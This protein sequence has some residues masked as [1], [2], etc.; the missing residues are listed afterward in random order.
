MEFQILGPLEVT[1]D[2][3]P[4]SLP[5]SKQRALLAILVLNANDVVSSDRLI[6]ELYEGHPVDKAL[7]AL[8]VQI[9]ALRKVLE[10]ERSQ[11][12]EDA[13]VV[14]RPPGY[15][16]RIEPG[17]LDLDA[18]DALVSS[19][20]E[21]LAG[22]DAETAS[23]RFRDALA[24]WRGSPLADLALESW[25]QTDI[26]RLEER[27]LGA[28]EERIEADLAL[29]RHHELVAEL[30]ALVADHPLRERIRRQL[31]LALYRCG[32]HAE[33]LAAY[34]DARTTLVDELGIEPSRELKALE[35]AILIQDPA[36][37]L[38]RPADKEPAA[39]QPITMPSAGSSSFVGRERELNEFLAA[40]EDAFGGRTS[41]LLIA[42]E[43]GIGK[44][45]LADELAARAESRGARVLWG[46]C[47]EAGGAPAYWPWVQAL[48]SYIRDAEPDELRKE[49]GAG[50]PEIAEVLPELRE[51]YPD[52]PA[53]PSLDA[54][55]ARFRL[56]DSTA[57][58][59]RAASAA[60]PLVILL[61]DIHAADAPSLLLLRFL[62]RELR[63]GRIALVGAY[64][65]S[66][67]GHDG[68]ITSSVAEL[69]REPITR[70]VGLGG[71][72]LGEMKRFIESTVGTAPGD[73]LAAAIHAETEGNPLFAG[74]LVRLLV[75][76]GRLEEAIRTPWRASIPRG[77]REVIGNRLLQLSDECK[78]LLSVASVL[79]REF[80]L[81]ALAALGDLRE[82]QMAGALDEALA[83]RVV[84]EEPG[85]R[86][87]LRFSHALIRDSLY[88]DLP[89]FERLQLHRRAA[90]VLEELYGAGD[91]QHLAELAHHFTEAAP[92]GGADKAVAYARRAGDRAAALLAYEEAARLYEMA[93][94]ALER[95]AAHDAQRCELLLA[96]GGAQS[97]GGDLGAA[98]ETFARAADAARE[99]GAP[100]QLG[101]AAL[102]YG[103][104][105]VWFR[106]GKDLRLLELLDEALDG[107]PGDSPL[108]A[109]LLARLAGALRD[110][111]VPERRA[112]LT[113]ESVEIARRLGDRATLAYALEGTYA[114]LSLP[115]DPDAWL[116]MG[117]ELCELADE[118]G[119]K[120]LA[121]NG[122][123]NAFGAFMVRGDIAMADA[124]LAVM[125]VLERELR[126]PAHSMTLATIEGMR[127]MLAGRFDEARNAIERVAAFGPRGRSSM[128]V[129]DEATFH[130][131]L[132]LQRWA[133][134][135]ETGELEEE[136]HRTIE[137][138][139]AEY[140]TFFM[141]RCLLAS[142]YYRVGD[143]EHARAELDRLAADGFR[144]L[145]LGA[146]WFF[147]T[148]LL[149]EVC[150]WLGVAEHAA[151]LYRAL[152]PY[153]EFNALAHPEFSLGCAS[154]YLG[155]LAS[156]MSMWDESAAHFER[157]L[158]VNAAMGGLPWVAHT[159][160]DYARM[161]LARDEPG[162]AVRAGELSTRADAKYRELGMAAWVGPVAHP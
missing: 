94:A 10:P 69:R 27:R 121:Y 157:A 149:A 53:A 146:E 86:G 66:E 141:F 46:R 114:S 139:V 54:E 92:A 35:Q 49:L 68:A 50:A 138:F 1:R 47:W 99:L 84:A 136:V 70:I 133:L 116:A 156:A 13:L 147:E 23:N 125:R 39:S 88:D 71:L 140:P 134:A 113:A 6:D 61:D 65:D 158:E 103:G 74:E 105:Y 77:V 153:G 111:P 126:Q 137:D 64:R 2:G 130:Y 120:E 145:D 82:D 155:M 148:N 112:A 7:A 62:A 60:C 57:A 75:A 160:D 59:L 28:V 43:P 122:H 79:G 100:E 22:G 51:L 55:G 8:H 40:L 37:D 34:R 52:L 32:R 98:K 101:R 115:R 117:R 109:R 67:A 152:M 97:R 107:L 78:R 17:Q 83:A 26:A 36:L 42:G 72:T 131:V 20:R 9:S 151:P 48:R 29:G 93:L 162:D 135:R 90:E 87:S 161:L 63:A 127:A 142:S 110:R 19:G 118:A 24:L 76:E 159:E 104:P 58:F 25:A 12:R 73:D 44:S 4:L 89:T 102:G 14:T 95:T 144:G 106:A 96:A 129:F 143:Q 31:M 18:F 3:S 124:E 11:R 80:R 108:R 132:Y 56:F 16:L 150:G 85:A 5:G 123:T 45:R 21:A 38:A 81:D 119:D 30:E 91:D 15:M 154:R 128:G 41:L 33:A